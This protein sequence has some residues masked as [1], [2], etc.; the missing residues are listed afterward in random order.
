V[1]VPR[2]SGL[3]LLGIVTAK[4]IKKEERIEFRCVAK[5]KRTAQM[6]ART[7]NGGF[8]L[9]ESLDWSNRHDDLQAAFRS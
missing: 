4:V 2:E 9:D 1:G 5:A 6:Y 3:I 7:F 8:R